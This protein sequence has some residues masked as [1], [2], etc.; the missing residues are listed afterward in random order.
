VATVVTAARSSSSPAAIGGSTE[1][2]NNSRISQDNDQKV[3]NIA[4]PVLH[5]DYD[6][7]AFSLELGYPG[8]L[9]V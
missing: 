5:Q 6:Y 2:E 1:S 9:G 7:N 3:V 4:K 8:N